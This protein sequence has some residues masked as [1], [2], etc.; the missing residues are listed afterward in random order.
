MT[1]EIKIV[2]WNVNSVNA[3][4]E[5]LLFY[6]KEHKPDVLLLQE[7]KCEE[8]K[9]P[10]EQ[11]EDLGYNVAIKGQKTYNGVAI[12]SKYPLEDIAKELPLFDLEES[13]E[14]ARYVEAVIPVNEQSIRVASIYV[15]NGGA[16]LEDGQKPNETDRF[17]YKMKFFDRL[18]KHFENNLKFNEI[19]V[20]GGDYNVG[21]F[22]I[23]VYDPKN[24]D[25]TV[26]FHQDE[27]AKFNAL[28][29]LGYSD[30]F[31]IKKPGAQQFSWWD[32]RGASFKYNK[33]MRIDYLLTS[34]LATDK[35]KDVQI[36][37]FMYER[38]KPSDHVPVLTVLE[39]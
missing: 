36:D 31:R 35:I 20:F 13:D 7:L 11:I 4:L 28:L 23:D 26:C 2:S 16:K 3:R 9:F 21:H 17:K 18:H 25:G 38:E 27:R 37:D 1:K 14:E 8:G 22:D 29:N 24:L 39:I 33:G 34:P 19:A 15:P 32:Y 30:S 10:L 12:L 5:N 6:L